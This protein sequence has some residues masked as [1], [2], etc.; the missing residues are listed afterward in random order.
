MKEDIWSW[1]LSGGEDHA[2]LGTN[3]IV[4]EGA[5]EIGEVVAGNQVQVNGASEIKNPGWRH[6]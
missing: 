4:P 2:F 3:E 5:F 6:F 1:V